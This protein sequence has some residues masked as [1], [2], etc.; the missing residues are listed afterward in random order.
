MR[1]NHICPECGFHFPEERQFTTTSDGQPVIELQC[2]SCATTWL[3]FDK[4]LWI[5]YGETYSATE[6]PLVEVKP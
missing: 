4:G 1:S 3:V 5:Y 6:R 2:P